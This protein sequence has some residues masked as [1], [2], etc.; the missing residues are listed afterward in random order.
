M[1][2]THLLDTSVYS[3]PFKKRPD[4]VA[5]AHWQAL[6]DDRLAVSVITEAEL[7]YGFDWKGADAQRREYEAGLRLR[8]PV[9]DMDS[10]VAIEYAKIRAELRRL[11]TP[12]GDMDLLI[13]A[14]ALAKGLVVATLN[15][16]DFTNIPGLNFEDWS[17]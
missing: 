4:S 14:T 2:A 13:A 7:R 15:V 9:L 11:G 3:Q 8:I 6:G 1:T 5:L 10:S 17:I 12:V 16:K